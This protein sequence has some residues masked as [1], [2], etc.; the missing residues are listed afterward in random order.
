MKIIVQ[1]WQCII[2]IGGL[3]LALAACGGV[4]QA[5]MPTAQ[6]QAA[7]PSPTTPA[8][9]VAATAAPTM[10]AMAT[11][12]EMT[13]NDSATMAPAASGA[14]ADATIKTFQY[15]PTPIEVKAGTTVTWT[16]EDEIEHSVTSGT[17]PAGTKDFDSG[18]FVKGGTFSQT[19]STAG[20]FPYFCKRHNSMVG[21]VKVIP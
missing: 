19:F 17:P 4:E 2:V 5:A 18:F 6:A 9:M 13:M 8:T 11:P 15:N 3:G 12:T 7:M 21:I 1:Y 16:N 10:A 14:T 20:E